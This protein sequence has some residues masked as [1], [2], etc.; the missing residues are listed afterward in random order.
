MGIPPTTDGLSFNGGKLFSMKQSHVGTSW[1]NWL[2]RLIMLKV[3]W[4][5]TCGAAVAMTLFF[6]L[7][8]TIETSTKNTIYERNVDINKWCRCDY[9]IVDVVSAPMQA[10]PVSTWHTIFTGPLHVAVPPHIVLLKKLKILP[11]N[12]SRQQKRFLHQQHCKYTACSWRISRFLINYFCAYRRRYPSSSVCYEVHVSVLS[13][14][15][16]NKNKWWDLV[17]PIRDLFEIVNS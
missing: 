10:Y 4:L 13:R 7:T 11:N 2:D 8:T 14:L 15:S 9:L 16:D 6:A 3:I 17:P 5:T 1:W 12:P